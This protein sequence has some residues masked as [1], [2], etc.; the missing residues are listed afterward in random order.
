MYGSAKLITN[1]KINQQITVEFTLLV[2]KH[3]LQLGLPV[4]HEVLD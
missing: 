3:Q 4:I 1:E 2:F